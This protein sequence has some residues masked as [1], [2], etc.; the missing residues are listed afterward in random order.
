MHIPSSKIYNEIR[1]EKASLWIVPANNGQETALLIKISTP[2]IKALIKGC[3]FEIL[4]GLKNNYLIMGIKIY[5]IPEYPVL[6]SKVIR[7]KEEIDILLRILNEEKFPFFLFNEMDICVANSFLNIKGKQII[8]EFN[9]DFYCG[10]LDDN[11]LK[12][13]DEFEELISSDNFEINNVYN[14]RLKIITIKLQC[15]EWKASLNS[16]IGFR[17]SHEFEINRE[18]EGN[19]FENMIWSSLESVF[20]FNLFKSPQIKVGNIN[21]EFTDIFAFSELGVFF[22]EAKDISIIQAGYEK[23]REKR[24]NGIQKQVKK[25]IAQ[26]KGATKV[27]KNNNIIF[28]S[29]G[30]EIVVNR[31]IIPHAIILVTEV[32]H[33]GDWSE[34]S[35]LILDA[36]ESTGALF[37]LIDFEELINILKSVSGDSLGFDYN[38]V[39]RFEKF[40]E[41]KSIHLR[42]KNKI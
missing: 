38:L 15:S 39:K 34:I 28:D 13:H 27:F 11:C 10:V 6:I 19:I 22:I 29:Q 5:D 9:S 2:I 20:N 37:H 26:L 42:F 23:T 41:C 35:N 12:F 36:S 3:N 31:E 32:M 17:E 24:I 16:F 7:T 8:T 33:I 40:I 18:D 30:S 1:S 21:R 25:A 14:P 4:L